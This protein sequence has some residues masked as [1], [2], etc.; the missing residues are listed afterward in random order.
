MS[1]RV[2]RAALRAFTGRYLIALALAIVLTGTAVA[3]VDREITQR[4]DD[5]KRV[6]LVVASPPPEGANYLILG[7]DTREFVSNEI[8]EEAF[9]PND[10]GKNS[11]TLMVAH[12]E[13]GAQRTLVVSFPRDLLVEVPG[14]AGTNKINAAYGT[15]GPQTVIEMLKA[16]FDIDVHH[17]LEVDFESFRQVVFAIGN[18]NTYFPYAARDEKTGLSIPYGGGCYPLDGDY[19]LAYV[20]SRSL[21]YLIDGKWQL[22][23]QDAPDIY[24]IQRQQDFIRKLAGLA[25]SRSLGDPFVALDVADRVLTYV[26]LDEG[27]GRDEVNSLIKAFRTV[28]VN[29]PNSVR[30][31]TLPVTPNPADPNSSLVL[32]EGAEQMIDRLRTFGDSTPKPPSVAPA[33]VNVRVIDGNGRGEAAAI[34]A[35]LVKLGFVAGASSRPADPV[36]LSEI[37]YPPGQVA[38]AKLLLSYFQ[39]ARL[40]LDPELTS[41]LQVVVGDSY[42]AITVPTTT[43]PAPVPTTAP[44]A[45]PTGAAAPAAS[46]TVVAPAPPTTTAATVPEVTTTTDPEAAACG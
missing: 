35:E 40:V 33:Q 10:G 30:F 2:T 43:A 26:R 44:D 39:D 16:N 28:D 45:V 25:I 9:G 17:Y 46:T 19:A 3:T 6:D 27:V 42:S 14:L 18:V 29:D 32:A 7:S 20:R 12:V 23:G 1:V 41:R 22:T 8:D 31:E 15:G 11:D 36:A 4:V 21:E 34:A 37:R 24:R 38:S 13:P 5:I